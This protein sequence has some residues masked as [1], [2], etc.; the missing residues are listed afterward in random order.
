M[1]R[2]QTRI[3]IA[4]GVWRFVRDKPLGAGGVMMV[5]WLL[6]NAVL[7]PWIASFPY[8]DTDVRPH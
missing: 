4:W 8:D 1:S 3:F 6:L 5:V 7:V 2:M